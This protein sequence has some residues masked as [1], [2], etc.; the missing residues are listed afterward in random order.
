MGFSLNYMS[1]INCKCKTVLA[2]IALLL[3]IILPLRI[4]SQADI[5]ESI[6]S[7]TVTIAS[8]DM[9]STY[10][11]IGDSIIAALKGHGYK[12]RVYLN[13]ATRGSENNI[14]LLYY[15]KADMAIA[16]SDI[17]A[18]YTQSR[19]IFGDTLFSEEIF[20]IGGIFNECVHVVASKE[21][22]VTSLNQLTNR[23]IGI[24]DKGSGSYHNARCILKEF[25]LLNEDYIY[26]MPF[27][28]LIDAF[29][30]DEIDAFI[31]TAKIPNTYVLKALESGKGRLI[32]IEPPKIKEIAKKHQGF[33]SVGIPVGRYENKYPTLN[34]STVGVLAVL[35]CHRDMPASLVTEA[36]RGLLKR[37]SKMG[38]DGFMDVRPDKELGMSVHPGAKVVYESRVIESTV[39]K[40]LDFFIFFLIFMA[41]IVLLLFFHR[42]RI[43]H[44]TF[45]P[46][47][48]KVLYLGL[49]WILG[50]FVMHFCE[51]SL[52]ANFSTIGNSFWS[53]AVYLFSGFEDKFPVTRSGKVMSVILMVMGVGMIAAVTGELASILTH[54]KIKEA[55]KVRGD[56]SKH[57]ILINWS[58]KAEKIVQEIHDPVA[59]PDTLILVLDEKNVDENQYQ[60]REEYQKVQ[61]VSGDIINK[62]FLRLVGVHNARSIIILADE[63][64]QDPDART[65]LIALAINSL[66]NDYSVH[67]CQECGREFTVM[68]ESGKHNGKYSGD[69]SS[70][71]VECPGCRS[72]RVN[73]IDKGR[74]PHIVAETK[75][76][77][78]MSHLKAAGIDEIIC[79]SDYG[80]GI[81]AQCAI[82]NKLSEVY[83]DL[84]T[85]SDDT[86]EIY[87]LDNTDIPGDIWEKVFKGKSFYEVSKY[88]MD[89]SDKSDDPVILVGVR[90]ANR[91]FINPRRNGRAYR[92]DRFE[93]IERDHPIF[94][95]Y[96]K[97]DLKK[98]VKSS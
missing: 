69:G 65:A 73:I 43:Q 90:S 39:N 74:R 27:S 85:Y 83:H 55:K 94:I 42:S 3:I 13:K 34:V 50:A 53:N 57:I 61:F 30:N 52:N 6:K 17:L 84:L 9:K 26:E 36:A 64:H 79:S 82:Y 18:F 22:R 96:T 59:S 54:K 46:L 20:A 2:V 5:T 76:H 86:N 95:S 89:I 60:G 7:D 37:K 72:E 77:R 70:S 91:V 38:L 68:E 88:F 8:G 41:I 66:C 51:R 21:L 81:L 48:K 4:E 23:K 16:Q 97:P 80:I 56:Y 71:G 92:F 31:L 44:Y 14:R 67:K 33:F 10:Y 87:Q 35:I 28:G 45:T 98:L 49:I 25:Y 1:I 32:S 19:S 93:D 12:N 40:F 62:R 75:N 11:E 29:L 58:P 63:S 15:K 78:K 24:P 47:A